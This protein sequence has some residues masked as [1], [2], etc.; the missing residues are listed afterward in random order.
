MQA[1]TGCDLQSFNLL[2][3]LYRKLLYR[4]L[5]HVHQLINFYYNNIVQ[6]GN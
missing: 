3:I 4:A 1:I 2:H 6:M 5:P